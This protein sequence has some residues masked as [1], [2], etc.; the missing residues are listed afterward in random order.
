MRGK[1]VNLCIGLMNIV[2]GVLLL[3]FTIYVPQDETLLTVQENIV[4]TANLYGIYFV[5]T[6]VFGLNL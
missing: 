4:R 5:M 3:I 1:I 2:F 6:A